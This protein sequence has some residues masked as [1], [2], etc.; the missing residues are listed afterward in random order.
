L[1]D[2]S[3]RDQRV[4]QLFLA[5]ATYHQIASAT[6]MDVTEVHSVLVSE[7]EHS[8]DR[9]SVLASHGKAVL[10]ERTEALFRAHWA[11]ALRGDHRS[12]EICRKIL[13]TAR[14][15]LGEEP[16]QRKGT[17]LDELAARRSDASGSRRA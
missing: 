11:P 3:E 5:G 16:I 2:E 6:E 10:Q 8:A 14:L 1:A 12:A 4:F 13:D 17:A 15:S 9:R 7:L